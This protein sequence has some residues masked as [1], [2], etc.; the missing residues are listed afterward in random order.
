MHQH[1][2]IITTIIMPTTITITLITA[3]IIITPTI[4]I[5]TTKII[6]IITPIPTMPMATIIIPSTITTAIPTII[7][8]QTMQIILTMG[9][10]DPSKE[11]ILI[12][13]AMKTMKRVD[14]PLASSKY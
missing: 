6:T 9:N 12:V 10:E 5:S 14:G 2:T 1:L 8:A 13:V 3:I 4:E 11:V 7:T